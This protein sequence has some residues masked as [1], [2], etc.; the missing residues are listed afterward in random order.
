MKDVNKY[1]FEIDYI[2]KNIWWT[3]FLSN[4]QYWGSNLT[5][6]KLKRLEQCIFNDKYIWDD[7]LKRHDM[8]NKFPFIEKEINKTGNIF[9]YSWEQN[10][11]VWVIYFKHIYTV[12]KCGKQ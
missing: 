5:Y 4:K 12:E 3:W 6:A 1:E 2:D 8:K 9:P 7:L 10:P 11:W